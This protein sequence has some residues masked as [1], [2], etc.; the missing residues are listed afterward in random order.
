M[1]FFADAGSWLVNAGSQIINGLISGISGAIGGAISA[2]TGAVGSIIS[3][4]KSALGI[5]SPSKVFREI[6]QYT[7]M[8]LD[9][10]IS[11]NAFMASRSMNSAMRDLTSN[12]VAA[13]PSTVSDTSSA[14]QNSAIISELQGLK[15]SLKEMYIYLDGKTLVGGITDEMDKQLG[16]KTAWL[17]TR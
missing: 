2:V 4:A 15:Q 10:G 8:G 11:D 7:M 6:G 12:A 3:G 17:G 5:A 13:V 9:E 16:R 14:A 1:G